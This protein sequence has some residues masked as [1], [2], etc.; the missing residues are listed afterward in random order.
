MTTED[1]MLFTSK[2]TR[3]IPESMY[4]ESDINITTR[5]RIII[6]NIVVRLQSPSTDKYDTGFVCFLAKMNTPNAYAAFIAT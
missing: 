3:Q 4:S 6:S 2:N 1:I 5:N